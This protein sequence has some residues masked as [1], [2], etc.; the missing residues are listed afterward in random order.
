VSGRALAA[1]PGRRWYSL[2]RHRHLDLVANAVGPF[3]FEHAH[4]L[5]RSRD[6]GSDGTVWLTDPSD[7]PLPAIATARAVGCGEEEAARAL[8]ELARAGTLFRRPDGAYGVPR[9]VSPGTLRSR[10]YRE[11]RRMLRYLADGIAEAAAAALAGV[12]SVALGVAVTPPSVTRDVAGTL[13][14]TPPSV[15]RDVA[16]TLPVTPPNA[17]A[18]VAVTPNAT[19]HLQPESPIPEDVRRLHVA[20]PDHDDPHREEE[21]SGSSSS[22][23]FSVEHHGSEGGSIRLREPVAARVAREPTAEVADIEADA[24]FDQQVLVPLCTHWEAVCGD[25]RRAVQQP[26]AVPEPGVR[27]ALRAR[28]DCARWSDPAYYLPRLRDLASNEWY[29]FEKRPT[30]SSKPLPATLWWFVTNF[31]R[32]AGG[33]APPRSRSASVSR[34][35]LP[36]EPAPIPPDLRRAAYASLG[37]TLEDPKR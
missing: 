24:L 15:A 22:S 4:E 9:A 37:M 5:A 1:V 32:V 2:P 31:E 21:G 25:R 35:E 19:L 34:P 12:A 26:I 27:E 30:P 33:G 8:E 17:L 3:V 18:S 20:V 29:W 10:R 13:P 23:S 16:A 11:K 7:R 28:A 14:D 36:A 6:V